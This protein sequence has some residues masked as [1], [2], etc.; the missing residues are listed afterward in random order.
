MG[1]MRPMGNLW[2]LYDL[3]DLYDLYDLYE[4]NGAKIRVVWHGMAA[5]GVALLQ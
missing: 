3:C 5:T 2:D 1:P 4:E